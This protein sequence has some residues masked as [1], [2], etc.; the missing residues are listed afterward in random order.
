MRGFCISFTAIEAVL[1]TITGI[2]ENNSDLP[3]I[4]EVFY[5]RHCFKF[6]L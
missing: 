3:E 5:M 6:L 4:R 2:S 1:R